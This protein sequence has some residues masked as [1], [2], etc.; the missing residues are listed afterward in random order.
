MKFLVK[1]F[2]HTPI[3]IPKYCN[4][5][6]VSPVYKATCKWLQMNFL[7]LLCKEWHFLWVMV[8]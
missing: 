3:H 8:K 2:I 5:G 7:K 4:N 1:L 6:I